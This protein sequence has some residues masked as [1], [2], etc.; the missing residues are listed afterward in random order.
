MGFSYDS[1][2]DIG[3][4]GFHGHSGHSLSVQI[5]SY[6]DCVL[7]PSAKQPKV[8]AGS[9]LIKLK[10]PQSTKHVD[11]FE[12]DAS[13]P[14]DRMNGDPNDFRWL[15]DLDGDDFY[16]QG[17]DK[18]G[19]HFKTWLQVSN[20][21]FYTRVVTSSTFDLV[22][23]SENVIKFYG[24]IAHVMAAAT[25]L[26][27]GGNSVSLQVDDDDPIVLTPDGNVKYQIVFRN[28]CYSCPEPDTCSSDETKRNDFHFARKV[29]K[30]PILK[31]KIGLKIRDRREASTVTD[32]C[33]VPELV[34]RTVAADP[35][36][37]NRNT[38]EA[39]CMGAGYGADRL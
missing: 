5:Y 12:R 32:V 2:Y 37:R 30:V 20:A 9:K 22:D 11:Y 4:V 34:N 18:N 7:L 14:F 26:S 29:L 16:P 39:P 17:Y 15:P 28:E 8:K 31:K 35:C 27:A 36:H 21:T 19:D 38:D 24:H 3:K 23:S 10:V 1:G 33:G 6:P 25:D 13:Q